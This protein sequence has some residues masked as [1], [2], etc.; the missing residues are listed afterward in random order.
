MREVFKEVVKRIPYI[1][2]EIDHLPH[3]PYHTLGG[4]ISANDRAVIV[5]WASRIASQ[6]P[7]NGIVFIKFEHENNA[8]KLSYFFTQTSKL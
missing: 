1:V 2:L 7:K 3:K 4:K 8:V 6:C 5:S